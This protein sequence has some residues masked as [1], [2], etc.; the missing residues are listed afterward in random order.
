MYS[1]ASGKHVTVLGAG[2]VGVCT[3]L[4]LL[5]DGHAVTLIDRDP[6]ATGCSFG[7][8]GL[9]QTGACVPIATPGV[10]RKVPAMLLDPDGPLV[11]RWRHL[12]TLAPY[13][14]RFVAA[15]RPSRVEEISIAL[16]AL[17]DHAAD[18]YR[19][20]RREAGASNLIRRS[21]ELYVYERPQAY[22]AAREWHDLRRRRG[23]EVVDLREVEPALAPSFAAGLRR[24]RSVERDG[25]RQSTQGSP[26]ARAPS[27]P[28]K[29]RAV[30]RTSGRC[31]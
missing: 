22:E 5:R 30:I 9:I 7:N 11:I 4:S 20:L 6:P 12:P 24:H 19:S 15:A 10:L 2:T 16:Q 26:H 29:Q 27:P 23:V 14:L 3:A 18:A 21:G 31:R 8:G 13:L 28:L 17:L 25:L 1:S